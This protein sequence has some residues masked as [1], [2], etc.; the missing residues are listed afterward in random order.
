[1]VSC[2]GLLRYASRKVRRVTTK[3]SSRLLISLVMDARANRAYVGVYDKENIILEDCVLSLDE[4]D[5]KDYNVIGD[6]S[7]VGKE[8][9]YVNIPEAFLATKYL[10]NKTDKI[11]YLVPKYLKVYLQYLQLFP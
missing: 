11:A 8:D 6:G 5:S 10:W 7:L 9:V 2:R 4:I 3:E 1:M